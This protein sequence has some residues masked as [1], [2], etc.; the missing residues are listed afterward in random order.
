MSVERL[1]TPE[2]VADAL[3]LRVRTVWL[4]LRSGE[5]RGVK[6]GRVWRVRE[7]DLHAFLRARTRG[8]PQ[9]K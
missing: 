9:T 2:E 8:G 6:L 7:E 1:L 4:Y 5:L 3:Q